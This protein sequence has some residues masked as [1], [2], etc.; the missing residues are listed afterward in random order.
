M[1]GKPFSVNGTADVA[2]NLK[3][4]P[5]AKAF[6]DTF[7]PL[8]KD[9]LVDG[10]ASWNNEWWQAMAAGKYA[11]WMAG[12]WA[13]AVMEKYI[14]QGKGQWGVAPMPGGASSE[15]GGSSVAVTAQAKNKAASVAF[16]EWLDADPEAVKS[17]NTDVG[18]FP[19]TKVLLDDPA[20]RSADLPYF[21]GE[22]PNEVF[23]DMSKAVRPGWQYLPYEVYADSIF[24]DTVGQALQSGGDLNAQLAAWQDRIK[25]YGKEQGFTI[26]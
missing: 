4:D 14:P 24:K 11:V 2:V 17:L 21:P 10:T 18:L 7:G 19:A 15:N 1:G 20:F 23:A 25:S 12:A 9:K 8:V 16:A 26:K 6:A 3:D 5:G 22:K 13:P